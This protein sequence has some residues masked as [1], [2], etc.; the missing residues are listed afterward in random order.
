MEH[1]ITDNRLS[2]NASKPM[3]STEKTTKKNNACSLNASNVLYI[4]N[5]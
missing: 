5:N 1:L 2:V 3:L 4:K